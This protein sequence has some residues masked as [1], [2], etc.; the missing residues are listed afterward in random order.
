MMRIS[1]FDLDAHENYAIAQAYGSIDQIVRW[2]PYDWGSA[3]FLALGAWQALVGSN[4]LSLRYLSVLLFVFAA[5]CAYAVMRRLA[6]QAAAPFAV[7]IYGAPLALVMLS[8]FT[9][10]YALLITLLP[11]ALYLGLRYEKRPAFLTGALLALSLALMVYIHITGLFAVLMIGLFL[12]ARNRLPLVALVR[13]WLPPALGAA[14]LVAPELF[15]KTGAAS[16]R[17]SSFA[18]GLSAAQIDEWIVFMVGTPALGALWLLLALAGLIGLLRGGRAPRAAW[19]L[20]AWSVL[21][22]AIVFILGGLI[23]APRHSWWYFLPLTLWV[24]W[25]IARLPRPVALGAGLLAAAI[26]LAPIPRLDWVDDSAFPNPPLFDNMRW[27][28]QNARWGDV[29]LVD[30]QSRCAPFNDEWDNAVRAYFPNGLRFVDDPTGY[31]RVWYVTSNGWNDADAL[32]AV[33]ANRLPGIF[34]GPPECLF[35]LY[36]GAPDLVGVPFANGLRFHGVE[37]VQ[38][39]TILLSPYVLHKAEPLRVRLW[40][41]VDHSLEADYSV[42]VHVYDQEGALVAQNDGAPQLVSLSPFDPA[43]QV[44]MV[45]WVPGRLYVDERTIEI[46]P[47]PRTY[48]GLNTLQ[49]KLLVYQ[50][51]DGVRIAAPGVDSD[52]RLPLLTVSLRAF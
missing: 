29:V 13:R 40:W 18:F 37:V 4:P 38:H 16:S 44:E 52:N 46:P 48:N 12:L 28:A 19:L 25:G 14:L 27:L 15:G 39:D 17:F 6:G 49:V 33:E 5:S 47:L 21:G 35:R 2:T 34:V 41:S 1:T 42:A 51:W 43:V 26:T 10:G 20:L 31:P 23:G 50:W 8:L 45:G 22:M 11:F 32:Q 7:L 30:P 3:S 9:R 36:A 24:A